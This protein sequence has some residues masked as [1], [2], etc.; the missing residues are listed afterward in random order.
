M[1]GYFVITS[2]KAVGLSTILPIIGRT[3]FIIF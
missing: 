1:L 2:L 3:D